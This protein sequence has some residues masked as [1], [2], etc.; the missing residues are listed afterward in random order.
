MYIPADRERP[1]FLCQALSAC[2]EIESR[3]V[4]TG[5]I[6]RPD[7]KGNKIF[8]GRYFCIQQSVI[9]LRN[10]VVFFPQD[11]SR[12]GVVRADREAVDVTARVRDR[13]IGSDSESVARDHRQEIPAVVD[14]SP[15]VLVIFEGGMCEAVVHLHHQPV[16]RIPLQT[17]LD[18]FALATPGVAQEL[19]VLGGEHLVNLLVFPVDPEKAELGVQAVVEER[20]FGSQLVV[21]TGFG[22]ERAV[23]LAVER[24]VEAACLISLRHGGIEHA[25]GGKHILQGDLWRDLAELEPAVEGVHLLATAVR[26]FIEKEIVGGMLI[27]VADA[28]SQ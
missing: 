20:V 18:A 5:H 22:A 14:A 28:E 11:A 25:G 21:P 8:C 3:I 9:R 26:F 4:C 10:L 17:D 19:P 12:P 23:F 7:R 16:D 15:F 6:F 13:I 2:L 27:I 24:G 1:S